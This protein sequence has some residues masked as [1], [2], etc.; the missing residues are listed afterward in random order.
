[1]SLKRVVGAGAVGV[2]CVFL[3]LLATAPMAGA[4]LPK[5]MAAEAAGKPLVNCIR[6]DSDDPLVCG[7]LRKGPRGKT[8]ARGPRGYR[9]LTGATGAQGPI[10]LTGPQGSTGSQGTQ[11]PVGPQGIQGA[12]GAPGPTMVVTGSKSPT[13]FSSNGTDFGTEITSVAMCNKP[14]DP[15]VYGGGAVITKQGNNTTGDV[16]SIEDSYPGIFQN[17][18]SVMPTSTTPGNDSTQPA[19][20][21]QATAIINNLTNGDDTF[22]QAYA[23][24]GP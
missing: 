23:V 3:S 16:V 15:E 9:G 10:G 22:V 8:G 17:A 6:F 19:N 18:N 13:I 20:A 5:A 7:V 24:C 4:T 14:Q 2:A 12:Q 21:Y 1:M 11:G